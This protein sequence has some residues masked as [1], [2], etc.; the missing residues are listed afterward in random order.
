MRRVNRATRFARPAT[1]ALAALALSM[2]TAHQARADGPWGRPLADAVLAGVRGGASAANGSTLA[3]GLQQSVT[4]NGTLVATT[5]L[6]VAQQGSQ[7]VAESTG[8]LLVQTGA[9]NSVIN[10]L[11]GIGPAASI[12]Q[13]SLDNQRL[14]TLTSIDVSTTI[15]RAYRDLHLQATLD[16]ATK[17]ALRR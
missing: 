7:L 3:F 9:G 15:L 5:S 10:G 13:N 17:N 1:L 12:V 2:P 8:P 11:S 14:Q 4:V 16:A 6:R